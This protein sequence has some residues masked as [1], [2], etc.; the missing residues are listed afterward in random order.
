[1]SSLFEELRR[2]L[3]SDAG[4]T[5]IS[6]WDLA[7]LPSAQRQII[8]LILREVQM[9]Y[10]ELTRAIA[11]LPGERRFGQS[12]LDEALARLIKQAWLIRLGQGPLITYRV[13]LRRKAGSRLGASIWERLDQHIGGETT[14]TTGK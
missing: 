1:M 11:S 5:G 13:N 14:T 2:K 4:K 9:A 8:R 12:E 6:A 10:P 7:Q 3:E